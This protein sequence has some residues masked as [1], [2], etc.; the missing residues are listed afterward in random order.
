MKEGTIKNTP[1]FSNEYELRLCYIQLTV[2]IYSY[3]QECIPVGCVSPASVV[4][5][6]TTHSPFAT[7]AP[8]RREAMTH[9]CE[10]ITLRQT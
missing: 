2:L 6:P 8:P 10:N 3:Q 4:V 1:N 9:S 7:H 5:P